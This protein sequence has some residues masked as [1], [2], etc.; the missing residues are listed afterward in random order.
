MLGK[1]ASFIGLADVGLGPQHVDL[2]AGGLTCDQLMWIRQVMHPVTGNAL[3]LTDNGLF[4]IFSQWLFI[5][6]DKLQCRCYANVAECSGQAREQ[7][8]LTEGLYYLLLGLAPNFVT[9]SRYSVWK[10]KSEYFVGSPCARS[11]RW[12]EGFNCQYSGL[13]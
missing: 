10:C 4:R 11:P 6:R 7:K 13:F 12:C 1:N 5:D 2:E 8:E 9:H 3:D